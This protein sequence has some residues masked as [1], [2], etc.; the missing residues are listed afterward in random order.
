MTIQQTLSVLDIIDEHVPGVI[1]WKTFSN[2]QSKYR[3]K[4]PLCL[5]DSRSGQNVYF[6]VNETEQL[7]LCNVCGA[8]GNAWQLRELL[9]GGHTFKA[10]D[11]PPDSSQRRVTEDGTRIP[12]EGATIAQLAE[13]RGLDL[14]WLKQE[15]GWRDTLYQGTPAIRMTYPDEEGQN[16]LTRYRVGIESGD[17]YRWQRF[18][19]GQKQ[20]PYG[21]WTLPKA[22]EKN[23][24]VLVEG[25]TDFATCEYNDIPCLGIPG[26]QAWNGTWA[27]YLAGIKEVFVWKEP[28]AAGQ[29]FVEKIRKSRPDILVIE[30]PLG[31]KDPNEMANQ[32]GAGF[33]EWFQEMLEEARTAGPQAPPEPDGWEVF[34]SDDE[35][36]ATGKGTYQHS[37]RDTNLLRELTIQGYWDLGDA[38]AANRVRFCA[39]WKR[40]YDFECGVSEGRTYHC[41]KKGCPNCTTARLAMF[42]DSKMEVL[43]KEL[44]DPV[45]LVCDKVWTLDLTGEL[46]ADE[47]ILTQGF[48]RMRTILS[49]WTKTMGKTI[50]LAHDHIYALLCECKDRV[51]TFG[52]AVLGNQEIY[53]LVNMEESLSEQVKQPVKG[54]RYVGTPG[55]MINLFT[56]IAAEGFKWEEPE[57]FGAWIHSQKGKKAI[58]GKGVFYG[59]SGSKP[60][61]MEDHSDVDIAYCPVHKMQETVWKTDLIGPPHF[62]YDLVGGGEMH[63]VLLPD[64]KADLVSVRHKLGWD[65]SE[66]G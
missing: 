52:I 39:L 56:V 11:L 16:P 23:Y 60:P 66:Y 46:E 4:C 44:T 6:L 45:V 32:S 14:E 2:P 42:F 57:Q 29:A 25:E 64:R 36:K 35:R 17:R 63:S 20:R 55:K 54:R 19:N 34:T 47:G 1:R 53:D 27:N 13:K 51:A 28:D 61:P 24:I 21:L 40:V 10:P 15:L 62:F 7:W 38:D 31:I 65:M 58:Q 59:V 50:K 26:A 49:R 9:T 12:L 8:K 43:E 48:K 18:Q 5:Y 33:T 37:R 22:R 30:P 3:G 41:N